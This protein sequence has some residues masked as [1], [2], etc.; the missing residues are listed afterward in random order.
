MQ[1]IAFEVAAKGQGGLN[2]NDAAP[3]Y[4]LKSLPGN[5]SGLHLAWLMYVAFQSIGPDT[6]IGFD[7]SKEYAAAE[8]LH[9]G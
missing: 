1:Q 8:V 3:K 6:E 5:F 2:T 7:L 4:Q 9:H